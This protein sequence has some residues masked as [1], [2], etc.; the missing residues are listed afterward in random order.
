MHCYFSGDS[1][2][3]PEEMIGAAQAAGLSGICFTDHLDYDFPSDPP[4]AFVPDLDAYDHTINA[5]TE[6]YRD[7]FPVRH[8]IEIGIQPHLA[9]KLH[10]VIRE[11]D[12]DLVICS[13]HA[14][15]G[16]DPYDRTFFVGR[17]ERESYLR[18]FSSVLENLEVFSDF[19]V[20][21]HIDYVVRYG[22]NT[23]RFYS[24]EAYADVLDAILKKLIAMGKGIEI[25]TGGF[26]YG[27][28]HPNPTEDVLKRYR[29]L[30]GEIITIGSDAHT[31]EH[32]AYDFGKVPGIL[33]EA[34][35]RYYTIF[36]KRQPQ[37]LPL[38]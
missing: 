27:L 4:D 21:G 37:F 30:G 28:G 7:T 26:K 11:H 38:P 6:K 10:R 20:Y 18:Y 9:E 31:P 23:N 25:N 33:R 15:D 36:E 17:E 24:Y 1:E 13:S 3:D 2:A 22:P 8:G 34:G 29:E 32:V 12:Y 16:L 35:F 14:I 5:L 19:D